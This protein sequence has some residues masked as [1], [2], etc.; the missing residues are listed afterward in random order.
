MFLKKILFLSI[1]TFTNAFIPN[2]INRNHKISAHEINEIINYADINLKDKEIISK[3]NGFYGIIGPDI[4]IT[5]ISNLYNLFLGNGNIQG[6][7]FNNGELKFIKYFIR[8][9]KILF[10]ELN[11]KVSNNF[12]LIT[13]LTIINKIFPNNIIPNLLGAANT[14]IINIK[15]NSYAL[16][17]QDYP[18]KIDINFDKKQIYTI[19]KQKINKFEHFSAHS[20]FDNDIIHSID[21]DIFKNKVEYYSMNENFEIL[22]KITLKTDYI[23]L[24]H[25]F[26]VLKDNILITDSPLKFNFEKLLNSN[27]PVSFENK[28]PT[29]IHII[30]K[31][32]GNLTTYIS[33]EGFYIFHYACYTETDDTIEF[34]AS[35]YENLDFS[36]LNVHGYYRKI[37]LNKKTKNVTIEKNLELETHNLEFPVKLEKTI[38]LPSIKNNKINSF[39]VCEG[40]NINKEIFIKDKSIC[41]EP[42]IT[43]IDNVPYLISFAYGENNNGFLLVINMNNFHTIEIPIPHNI[44][45]GFHSIFIKN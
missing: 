38:I 44:N 3:I 25:D 37:I 24:I 17:E 11:N 2:L 16:F 5:S 45:I 41:G 35:V 4:K 13:F 7:F 42:V 34:F 31:K 8:T 18:Y 9:E 12:M 29:K 32:N 33:D 19:G 21:Y 27:I 22:N 28:L 39:L 26:I 30:D 23:P 14:A 20:K 1:L 15:N 43:E 36:K 10:E 6:V 40:L